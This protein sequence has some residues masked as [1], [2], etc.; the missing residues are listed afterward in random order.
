MVTYC[1]QYTAYYSISTQNA[2]KSLYSMCQ[3]SRSLADFWPKLAWNWTYTTRA[4]THQM[5]SITTKTCYVDRISLTLHNYPVP[6]LLNSTTKQEIASLSYYR[7]L[8]VHVNGPAESRPSLC[9]KMLP[10]RYSHLSSLDVFT[11]VLLLYKDEKNSKRTIHRIKSQML[12][13][14]LSLWKKSR[15]IW[16]KL[17]SKSKQNSKEMSLMVLRRRWKKFKR[18]CSIWVLL[19]TFQLRSPKTRPAKCTTLH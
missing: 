11:E 13:R 8:I 14:T 3:A 15:D 12:S 18:W 4:L 7:K 6:F 17:P 1:W 19:R 16:S 9:D 10:L 5:W 2:S